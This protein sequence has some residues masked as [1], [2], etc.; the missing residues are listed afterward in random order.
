MNNDKLYI[1][2]IL[3]NL[4]KNVMIK[5]LTSKVEQFSHFTYI[6]TSIIFSSFYLGLTI[7]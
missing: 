1:L 7:S 6:N 3:I 2:G 5:Y 4:D